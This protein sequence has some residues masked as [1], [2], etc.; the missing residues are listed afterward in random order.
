MATIKTTTTTTTTTAASRESRSE[1]LV[2]SLSVTSAEPVTSGD[3]SSSSSDA[4]TVPYNNNSS[5][6]ESRS[7]AAAVVIEQASVEQ[8]PI[9]GAEQKMKLSEPTRVVNGDDGGDCPTAVIRNGTNRKNGH[10]PTVEDDKENLNGD[11]LL[12][13]A[14]VAKTQLKDGNYFLQVLKNEQIRLLAMADDIEKDVE[15]LKVS[16][17]AAGRKEIMCDHFVCAISF[18]IGFD[19]MNHR[20]FFAFRLTAW[21]LAR[22]LPAMYWRPLARHGFYAPRK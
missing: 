8:Q 3:N 17:A 5:T 4:V 21:S 14:P 10:H 2:D 7:G 15:Q 6:Q 16:L 18:I 19:G 1:S 11:Q 12:E 13:V 20:V 9:I 22:K